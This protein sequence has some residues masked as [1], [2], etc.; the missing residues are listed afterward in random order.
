MKVWEAQLR[1]RCTVDRLEHESK[2]D[3]E[4]VFKDKMSDNFAKNVAGNR[5]RCG[6]ARY[7]P[8][9]CMSKWDGEPQVDEARTNFQV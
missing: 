5:R 1:K 9:S 6:E 8:T 2:M 7:T 4:A 3:V